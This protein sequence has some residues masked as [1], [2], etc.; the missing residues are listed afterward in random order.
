LPQ[1]WIALIHP[2]GVQIDMSDIY[3]APAERAVVVAPS[4]ATILN[5]RAIYVGG[6]GDLAVTPLKGTEAV[7]FESVQAGSILPISARSILSTGTTA[8]AIVA[9]Y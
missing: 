1:H 3:T 5:C 8:T 2:T 7:V 4:D 6:G 9:L